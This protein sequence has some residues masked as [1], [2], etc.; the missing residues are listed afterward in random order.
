MRAQALMH[1]P[2]ALQV[3]HTGALLPVGRICRR[4]GDEQADAPEWLGSRNG[5]APCWSLR[6]EASSKCS[7]VRRNRWHLFRIGHL[8]PVSGTCR[9]PA[10]AAA[11]RHKER[12]SRLFYLGLPDNWRCSGVSQ[13]RRLRDNHELRVRSTA[14]RAYGS[15]R[16]AEMGDQDRAWHL[17]RTATPVAWKIQ[18]RGRLRRTGASGIAAYEAV[19]IARNPQRPLQ[20]RR[21]EPPRQS[22]H[23][24]AFRWQSERNQRCRVPHSRTPDPGGRRGS[25]RC[26]HDAR[27]CTGLPQSDNGRGLFRYPREV[28]WILCGGSVSVPDRGERGLRSWCRDGAHALE[29]MKVSGAGLGC[30]RSR[31]AENR[32]LRIPHPRSGLLH[33]WSV[34]GIGR[35][36]LA[37]KASLPLLSG[38][39][40]EPIC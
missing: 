17:E 29:Q 2:M 22:L 9:L 39:G 38:A 32:H 31:S 40:S 21:L 16:C 10:Q 4:T 18:P 37:S 19:Y 8:L 23:H 1:R 24:P 34:P 36:V 25:V 13:T 12:R 28:R 15:A 11:R 35:A 5:V 27:R 33:R 26:P 7:G 3:I 20:R 14:R 6:L 30:G